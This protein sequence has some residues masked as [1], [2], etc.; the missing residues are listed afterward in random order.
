MNAIASINEFVDVMLESKADFQNVKAQAESRNNQVKECISRF[1][2]AIRELTGRKVKVKNPEL[3]DIS[4][5]QTAGL[6]E[7]L[8]RVAASLEATRR[9]MKFINE[10]EDS[11]NI[12]VFGK[13]KAG[14]SYTGN[15][16]MG[17]VIRD[18]GIATSYDKIQPRPTVTVIDRGKKTTQ[19]KLAE[20]DEEGKEGFRVDPNEATST[21]QLFRLGGMVWIDTPGIGS[22]TWDNEMLAKSFVDNADLIVYMSNSDAAGTQQD[23]KELKA[24]YARQKRFVLLLTQSD[25]TP[26][27]VDDEGNIIRVLGPRSEKDRRDMEEYIRDELVKH[28]IRINMDKEVLTI[29]TKLAIEGLKNNDEA[30]FEASNLKK[31]LAILISITRNEAGKLKLATPSGRINAMIDEIVKA[32]GTADGTLTEH[33]KILEDMKR[34]LSED[35][36]NLQYKMLNECMNKVTSIV[37]SKAQEV[38]SG[39]ASLSSDELQEIVSREVYRVILATCTEKFAGSENILSEYAATLKVGGISGL[40]MRHDTIEYNRQVSERYERDPDG[41]IE[42]VKSWFGAK[43]HSFRLK[44]I[45]EHRN[46]DLGVNLTEVLSD[47]R[48]SVEAIFR[49]Q[50][51]GI[52]RKL[53]DS[54]IAPVADL[55]KSAGIEIEKAKRELTGLKC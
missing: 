24:L 30:M 44:T 18:L 9:G 19:A 52:M 15:F 35:N 8:Q 28:G 54:L 34:T 14:K 22:V 39:S 32:L 53:S 55:R 1:E 50:V 47:V 23:F 3:E 42:H 11:F 31:F 48:R 37:T 25:D 10:Y 43:F 27:D 51:P 40:S 29:S 26:E 46:I 5:K 16:I 38:E 12:A 13:V 2:A 7:M 33:M 49:E 41:I 17:N 20:F 36:E 4:R 6:E 45:T 21:I